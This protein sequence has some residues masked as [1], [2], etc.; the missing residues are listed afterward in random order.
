MRRYERPWAEV[1]PSS[2]R[3]VLRRCGV[4]RHRF[5]AARLWTERHTIPLVERADAPRSRILCY[6]SVGTP[7]WG[8]NDVAP[9]QFRRQIE[10]A[11][12]DGYRFLPVHDVAPGAPERH[13][14]I[15]F[16]DGCATVATT[17]APILLEFGIPWT[18]F[19]VTGW[20]DGHERFADGSVLDW[21]K[22]ERLARD[23]A[24]IG[25]HSVTHP[26]LSRLSD[27]C[28][29][30]ELVESR[31]IIESR[32]GIAP[33]AFAIPM[34]CSRDW[35]TRTQE[36]ARA[37]GYRAVYAQSE[38]RRTPGTVARTFVTRYDNDRIFRAALR[39]AFDRWEEWV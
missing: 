26:S 33:E 19:I 14:A 10:I 9:A 30:Y 32:L 36:L 24:S 18:V 38:D 3:T 22:V 29:E 16:D 6:H 2:A 17:A 13:L 8:V 7:R 28:A 39:G 21:R 23:G 4:R 20:A 12:E 11:L 5:A 35:S 37:A 31:R 1:V 34:G 27:A 15:T 25:S